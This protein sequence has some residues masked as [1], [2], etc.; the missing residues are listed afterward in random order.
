MSSNNS[1]YLE[2]MREQT[3]KLIIES[4]KSATSRASVYALAYFHKISL[5]KTCET[6]CW[7]KAPNPYD[8][9]TVVPMSRTA[10]CLISV[11]SLP[12]DFL[13]FLHIPPTGR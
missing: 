1:K 2:E 6:A 3:A 11:V 13:V 5:R 9:G 12:L 8:I 10:F 7:G 4:G